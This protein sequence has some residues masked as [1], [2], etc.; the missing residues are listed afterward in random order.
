MAAGV[1]QLLGKKGASWARKGFAGS[2]GVSLNPGPKPALQSA[3]LG[4]YHNQELL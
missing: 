3:R 4:L 2:D 1:H